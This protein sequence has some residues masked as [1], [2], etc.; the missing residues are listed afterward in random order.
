MTNIYQAPQSDLI[1]TNDKDE[2]GVLIRH[3]LSAKEKLEQSRR[4]IEEAAAKQRL[5][6]VWGLRLIGDLITF[7]GFLYLLVNIESIGAYA[8]SAP[9]I[10]FVLA[11]L[12][13]EIASIIGYFKNKRWSKWPLHIYAGL[14]L[15]NFPFGTIL[16][17]I[18][19]LSAYK[20]Q[21]KDN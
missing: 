10:L 21:Y 9:V 11:Y 2:N 15:L 5:N 1:D 18:H 12:A 7:V 19:F 20:L 16:S 17:V 13:G 14:S 8:F 4:D 3:K 6:F